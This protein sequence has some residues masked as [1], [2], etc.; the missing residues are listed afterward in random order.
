MYRK[1][2][3]KDRDAITDAIQEDPFHCD[4]PNFT[5]DF[6][7][8]PNSQSLVFHDEE[9]DVC[10]LKVEKEARIHIQFKE[11]DKDRIRN[12]LNQHTDQMAR[13]LK[14]QGYKAMTFNSPNPALVWFMR[15]FGFRTAKDEF[16]KVL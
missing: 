11:V 10:Y 1:L 9:G 14:S 8:D 15:K 7:Y 5:S 6:F 16:R 13:A 3:E 4:N 2:E 12:L